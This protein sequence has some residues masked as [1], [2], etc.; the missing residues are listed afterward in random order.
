MSEEEKKEPFDDV[1]PDDVINFLKEKGGATGCP[2]CAQN[3]WS[4]GIN[5]NGSSPIIPSTDKNGD[6]IGAGYVNVIVMGCNN[7]GF[8]R[9]LLRQPVAEWVN[10][11]KGK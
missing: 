4:M 1:S 2:F 5:F 9:S 11:Q 8:I 10:E 7:C 6:I 3:S